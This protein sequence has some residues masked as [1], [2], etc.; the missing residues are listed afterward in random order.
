LKIV[1]RMLLWI[2]AL[3]VLLASGYVLWLYGASTFGGFIA[4]GNIIPV[5]DTVAAIALLLLLVSVFFL[6]YRT[7]RRQREPQAV[8]HKMENGDVK[9]TYETLEQ[10]AERAAAKIRGVQNL[11]TR[12]RVQEGGALVIGVRF[13]VEADLDIPKTTAELQESVKQ[14]VEGTTGLSVEQV[15]VYVT[16]L[17]PAKE[18]VKKRVE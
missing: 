7:K 11:K 12:V 10:L 5:D 3:A 18:T 14:Y 15:T 16:E 6:L 2:Y 13:S 8:T 9:I 17:A 1:P 4:N